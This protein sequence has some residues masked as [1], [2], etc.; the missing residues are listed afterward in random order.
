[1]GPE[2]LN[3]GDPKNGMFSPELREMGDISDA[4]NFCKFSSEAVGETA[5]LANSGAGG[6][7]GDG[8]G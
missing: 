1:V 7:S 3:G 5:L 2:L 4:E 6:A 8:G